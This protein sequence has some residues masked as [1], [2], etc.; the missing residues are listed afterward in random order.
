MSNKDIIKNEEF[1]KLFTIIS[2]KLN[3]DLEGYEI[4]VNNKFD[5]FIESQIP[6]NKICPRCKSSELKEMKIAIGRRIKDF[7]SLSPL[8]LMSQIAGNFM[9]QFDRKTIKTISIIFNCKNCAYYEPIQGW[10][11]FLKQEA[12]LIKELNDE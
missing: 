4:I 8:E 6:T 11:K 3:I 9:P 2:H 7:N 5:R 12:K 10:N 1:I